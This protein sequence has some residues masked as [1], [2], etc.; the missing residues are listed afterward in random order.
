[1]QHYEY[2]VVPAP[3]KGI[4]AK[5]VKS[6]EARFALAI[7]ALMNELAAEGWEYLRADVLPS[8]ERAGLTGSSTEWRNLLV[9]RRS[10]A[11]ARGTADITE[12]TETEPAPAGDR[13]MPEDPQLA[14]DISATSDETPQD[15]EDEA[16]T[17]RETSKA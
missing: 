9:F 7:E 4:K 15:D 2:K 1:M 13:T 12:P 16:A 10:P 17:N 5:G 8:V 11:V 3:T 6:A 14:A